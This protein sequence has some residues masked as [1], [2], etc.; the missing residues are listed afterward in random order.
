[1]S[2]ATA[3][4]EKEKIIYQ[5]KLLKRV[6]PR[7]FLVALYVTTGFVW[8]AGSVIS[9]Q[10]SAWVWTLLAY[11]G[12][13]LLYAGIALALFTR[14]P[15]ADTYRSRYRWH[16]RFP[17]IGYYPAANVPFRLFRGV[18]SHAFTIGFLVAAALWIWLPPETAASIAF[19]HLWSMLPRLLVLRAMQRHA[20]GG[21]IISFQASDVGLY[22]P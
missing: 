12:W 17:W 13:P 10:P 15:D 19:V 8:F 20:R 22:S 14:E 7:P 3:T 16:L 1:M 9:E 5:Y 18:T 2:E 21:A 6:R 11:L 4:A